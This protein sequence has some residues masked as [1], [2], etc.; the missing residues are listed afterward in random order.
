MGFVQV[1]TVNVVARAHHLT[2]ASRLDGYRPRHLT[3]LSEE[4]RALFEHFTHDASMIPAGFLRYWKPRFRHYEAGYR[5]KSWAVGR[6]GKDPD[7]LIAHVVGRIREEGPLMSKD[8]Q[9]DRRG[10]QSWWGWTPQKAALEFLWGIGTLTVSGRRDF[11][12]LYDLLERVFPEPCVEPDEEEFVDW[13]CS[14]ALDRLGVATPGEIAAFW[15][16]VRPRNA[17]AWCR[18]ASGEGRIREVS[19]EAADGSAPRRAFAVNDWEG[20]L[21]R[22]PEAPR[23]IRLLSPFDPVI[24]DRRRLSRLFA[25]DYRVEIFV[26]PA[27]RKYGYYVMPILEDERLIGRL[28]PKLH[29][30]RE[31]LEIRGV[32]WEPGIKPTRQ[33]RRALADAIERLA[34]LVGATS[35]EMA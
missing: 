33:R 2:L 29:R 5:T 3:R 34:A 4:H 13:A 28:D 31:T 27:Q 24:R 30:D 20:R 21:H 14:S 11:H 19:V 23:R 7:G 8:F 1:D 6:L 25:F 35:I 18:R 12:K 26:P 15:N 16:S 32:W 22:A 17:T 9:H 10:K